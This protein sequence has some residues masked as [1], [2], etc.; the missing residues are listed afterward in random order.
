MRTRGH[1][2]KFL[3]DKYLVK[4]FYAEFLLWLSGLKTHLVSMRMQVKS[5]VSIS[6]LRIQC[7]HELWYRLPTQ[8]RSYIAVAVS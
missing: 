3:L 7:R 6:G 1:I 4:N 8:L 2:L 5:L